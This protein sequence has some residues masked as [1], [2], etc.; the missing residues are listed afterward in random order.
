MEMLPIAIPVSS[1]PATTSQSATQGADQPIFAQLFQQLSSGQIQPGL[2]GQIQPGLDEQLR[3]ISQLDLS[4]IQQP[5]QGQELT[6]GNVLEQ[7][8]AQFF[9][10]QDVLGEGEDVLQNLVKL[11]SLEGQDNSSV[12]DLSL[13]AAGD[14][15]GEIDPFVKIP[16]LQSAVVAAAVT[17]PISTGQEMDSTSALEDVSVSED[18]QNIAAAALNAAMATDDSVEGGLLRQAEGAASLVKP[19]PLRAPGQGAVAVDLEQGHGSRGQI[20]EAGGK[21]GRREDSS[22]QQASQ[23]LVLDTESE[24]SVEPLK[25]MDLKAGEQKPQ[26]ASA[27]AGGAPVLEAAPKGAEAPVLTTVVSA[28]QSPAPA[29]VANQNS[30]SGLFQLSTGQVIPEAEIVDQVVGRFNYQRSGG[31]STVK[32]DLYPE[33]LGNVKVQLVFEKDGVKLHLHAQ[34]QQIQDVLE[35]HLPRLRE[36]FEQQGVKLDNVQVSSDARQ[37][38]RDGRFEQNHKRSAGG[39]GRKGSAASVEVAGA[40]PVVPTSGGE[41]SMQKSISLRV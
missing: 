33:E 18:T 22:Q 9:D 28:A 25:I 8:Q 3:E 5:L 34:S 38:G 32:M 37:D 21:E 41:A 16:S 35:R 10:G 23:R 14:S 36:A 4:A 1:V 40:L 17:V 13:E 19:E 27:G 24:E 26:V 11:L 31:S 12:D 20:L 30:S 7:L 29:S 15:S 39:W 2:D 6:K